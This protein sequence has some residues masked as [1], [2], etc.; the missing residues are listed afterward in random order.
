MVAYEKQPLSRGSR[1]YSDWTWKFL[2]FGKLV[3]EKR[4]LK[5]EVGPY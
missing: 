3:A 4:W 2:V 5:S 1:Y